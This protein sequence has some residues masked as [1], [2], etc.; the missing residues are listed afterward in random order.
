MVLSIRQ[1]EQYGSVEQLL[2]PEQPERWWPGVSPAFL[3]HR[4]LPQRVC[5]QP[6]GACLHAGKG[7]VHSCPA[8]VYTRL[9]PS[10]PHQCPGWDPLNEASWKPV[11]GHLAPQLHR[12]PK[13]NWW[14]MMCLAQLVTSSSAKCT[15]YSDR[16][17]FLL[18]LCGEKNRYFLFSGKT[19]ATVTKLPGKYE[20]NGKLYYSVLC[21]HGQ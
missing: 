21:Y 2:F 19:C 7:S 6:C 5:S 13:R 9:Q 10:D 12:V 8:A 17:F 11:P 4:R 14:E 1:V 18:L 3:P 15:L 16:T 20:T